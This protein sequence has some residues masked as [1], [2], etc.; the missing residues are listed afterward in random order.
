MILS[1]DISK[2]ITARIDEIFLLIKKRMLSSGLHFDSGT[3]FFLTGE[4]SLLTN[5]D[6]YCSNFFDKQIIK[7]EEKMLVMH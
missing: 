3:E 1:K 2:V 6:K 5:V 7:L 4:G